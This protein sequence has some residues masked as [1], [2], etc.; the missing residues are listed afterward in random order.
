MSFYDLIYLI[1]NPPPSGVSMETFDLARSAVPTG[2]LLV[3]VERT[4]D[5][6]NYTLTAGPG[7]D[8]SF[9]EATLTRMTDALSQLAYVTFGPE[10][11]LDQSRK[12]LRNWKRSGVDAS[13]LRWVSHYGDTDLELVAALVWAVLIDAICGPPACRFI[14]PHRVAV[15]NSQR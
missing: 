1:E 7:F 9:L 8:A 3:Q 15:V 4:F 14:E 10:S 12:L 13:R 11:R 2:V 5:G 6:A